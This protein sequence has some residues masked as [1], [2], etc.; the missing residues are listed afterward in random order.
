MRVLALDTTTR[1]GSAALVEDDRVMAERAGDATRTHAERLP[2][3]LIDLVQAAG[4]PITAV[5]I[6]AVAA[7]PGSFTGLR[8]GIACVQGLAVA[9]GRAIVAVSALEAL[10]QIG[11]RAI[12]RGE[13]IGVWMDAHRREVF[14]ALYRVSTGPEF[15]RG[16]LIEIEA[17]AVGD[18]SSTLSRWMRLGEAPALIV[19]E[20]AILYSDRFA[21][22]A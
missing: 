4:L 21:D 17:P 13:T 12:G 18:P 15:T 10:G 2:G 22:Q 6:F 11:S 19:G 9:T 14:S 8:I 5:D 7:G 1:T 16:R 20:G 3:E